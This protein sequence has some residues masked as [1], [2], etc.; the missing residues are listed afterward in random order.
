MDA[1][2]ANASSLLACSRAHAS[3]ARASCHGESVLGECGDEGGAAAPLERLGKKPREELAIAWPVET[4]SS[5]SSLSSG[6]APAEKGVGAVG[7]G[8]RVR[9]EEDAGVRVPEREVLVRRLGAAAGLAHRAVSRGKVAS[10]AREKGI[11][12][13]SVCCS[14]TGPTSRAGCPQSR[15]RSRLPPHPPGGCLS[16]RRACGRPRRLPRGRPHGPCCGPGRSRRRP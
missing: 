5:H 12:L 3:H 6:A 11:D 7:A 13:A 8:I 9:C 2:T 16:P 10:L 1:N 14:R 15:E 4:A